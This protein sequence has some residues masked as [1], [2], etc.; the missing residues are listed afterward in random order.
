MPEEIIQDYG[1]QVTQRFLFAVDRIIGNR[2]AGKITQQRLGD[3]IGI[4]SSNINRLRT[5][6]DRKVTLEA[7]CRLCDHYKISAYWL[8]L[9]KG[10]MY[11]NDELFAAYQA[12]ELRTGDLEKT[13]AAI[14]KSIEIFKKTRR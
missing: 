10:E 11:S 6:P 2:S 14:E 3:T 4:S 8:L 9:G 12:L 5:D 13:V 7:C 1:Y